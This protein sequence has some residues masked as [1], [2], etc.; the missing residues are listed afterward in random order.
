MQSPGKE[1][2]LKPYLKKMAGNLTKARTTYFLANVR[3]HFVS[4]RNEDSKQRE[5]GNQ[6]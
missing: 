2:L 1:E 4:G 6:M 3:M 5:N